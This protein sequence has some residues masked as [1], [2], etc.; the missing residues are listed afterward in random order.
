MSKSQ[1]DQEKNAYLP[2]SPQETRTLI[3]LLLD[4]LASGWRNSSGVFSKFT[5]ERKI[6]P[7]VNRKHGGDKTHKHYLN[8][9]KTLKRKYVSGVELLSCS[10]GLEGIQTQNGLQHQIRCGIII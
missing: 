3:D 1:Q 4:G 2:W 10:P 9:M 6:L 7:I 8:R 5:V